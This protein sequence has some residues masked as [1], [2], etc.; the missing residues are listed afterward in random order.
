VNDSVEKSPNR[1]RCRRV[2]KH[3]KTHGPA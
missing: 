3:G 2:Q 1:R